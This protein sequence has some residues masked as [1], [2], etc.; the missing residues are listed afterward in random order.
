MK[1]GGDAVKIRKDWNKGSAAL[2]ERKL[3]DAISGQVDSLSTDASSLL[4]S[5]TELNNT[6]ATCV[7]EMARA[8]ERHLDSTA[9]ATA[10][11]RQNFE[12]VSK[13]ATQ[14]SQ[15]V[16]Q[17]AGAVQQ[18]A[19]RTTA[20]MENLDNCVGSVRIV[21][22]SMVAITYLLKQAV[23]EMRQMNQN[24]KR[25]KDELSAQNTLTSSGGSGPDGFA[26]VVYGNLQSHIKKHGGD[27]HRF[28][29]WHP[30]N[31]WHW[32]FDQLL[33]EN[34]LPAT[35]CAFA[36]DLDELCVIM[37]AARR[38][39]PEDSGVVFHLIVSAW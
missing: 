11:I 9:H 23:D 16:S 28:F 35:F 24:L 30:D 22:G 13:A 37:G 36:S 38:A 39:L 6:R 20:T 10:S 34:P 17:S 7:K 1:W 27:G 14:A 32:R 25:I 2:A 26:R 29:V 21:A 5:G 18:A 12:D 15:S 33:E 4:K 8:Y 3:Y 31:T 19:E